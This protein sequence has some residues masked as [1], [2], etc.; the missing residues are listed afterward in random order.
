[1][2]L[3]SST[4]VWTLIFST[5]FLNEKMTRTKSDPPRTARAAAATA[6]GRTA[7]TSAAASPLESTGDDD[8][9]WALTARLKRC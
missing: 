8:T 1:M 4:G 5:I 2:I 3:S 6:C 7:R 9:H